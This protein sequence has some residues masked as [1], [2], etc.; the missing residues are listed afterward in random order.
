[1]QTLAY[2]RVNAVMWT[3]SGLSCVIGG[4]KGWV[5]TDD[6]VSCEDLLQWFLAVLRVKGQY[7]L[8]LV[9][10][11]SSSLMVGDVMSTGI[12]S[13][14]QNKCSLPHFSPHSSL[15]LQSWHWT[16]GVTKEVVIQRMFTQMCDILCMGWRCRAISYRLIVCHSELPL[17]NFKK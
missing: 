6:F 17:R 16:P 8:P 13:I 5:S 10:V 3:C 15:W 11:Y 14:S 12:D 4:K 1:M 9:N 2:I 7:A